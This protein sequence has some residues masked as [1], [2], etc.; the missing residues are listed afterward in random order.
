M[1][2]LRVGCGGWGGVVRMLVLEGCAGLGTSAS[3]SS[4]S[5]VGKLRRHL[6]TAICSAP[7]TVQ[8]M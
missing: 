5:L 4:L 3:P 6:P 7:S 2:A 8:S 1:L